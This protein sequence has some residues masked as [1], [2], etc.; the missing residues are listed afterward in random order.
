MGET[1]HRQAN[2]RLFIPGHPAVILATQLN[3]RATI[4][5][6]N[7]ICS[8]KCANNRREIVFDDFDMFRMI[9]GNMRICALI[10]FLSVF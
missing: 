2:M 6:I 1:V 7:P 3:I 4:E 9:I 5:D 8:G 10:G